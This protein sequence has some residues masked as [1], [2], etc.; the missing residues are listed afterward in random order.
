VEKYLIF[1]LKADRYKLTAQHCE[2]IHKAFSKLIKKLIITENKYNLTI[3]PVILSKKPFC[4]SL[5]PD[6]IREVFP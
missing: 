3:Y 5:L 2:V 1:K 4:R 6:F